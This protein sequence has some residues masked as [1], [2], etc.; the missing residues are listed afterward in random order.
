V[1]IRL[2]IDD[3]FMGHLQWMLKCP[4]AVHVL[5]DA[6]TLLNWAVG[7]RAKGRLI[8][9]ANPEG[10]DYVRVEMKSLE[11]VHSGDRENV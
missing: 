11:Y 6:L 1:E 3:H 4:T 7:E 5:R 10:T 8:L 9:S 2:S